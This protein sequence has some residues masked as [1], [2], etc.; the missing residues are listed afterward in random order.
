MDHRSEQPKQAMD[1]PAVANDDEFSDDEMYTEGE[2]QQIREIGNHPL[3]DRVQKSLLRQ[4]MTEDNRLTL[5]LR[6]H[7]E[8]LKVSTKSREQTGV[9]L[10]NVQQ[11]L[12]KL[13][14]QLE[15]IIKQHGIAEQAHTRCVEVV[16]P[17][18]GVGRSS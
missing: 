15:G 14:M 3:M 16:G 10:Y 2:E 17:A 9:E 1:G 4:L 13:Q 12:A 5:E 18:R 11:Q 6:E 8:S 7:R